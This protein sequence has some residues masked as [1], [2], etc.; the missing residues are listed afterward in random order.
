MHPLVP[1]PFLYRCAVRRQFIW[2]KGR[3]DGSVGLSPQQTATIAHVGGSARGDG[4]VQS[5]GGARGGR[6]VDGREALS[7]LP[8]NR[9][10]PHP[11]REQRRHRG[12]TTENRAGPAR[13]G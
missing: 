10:A 9:S 4:P 1:S 8:A 13:E 12:P 11:A 7:L 2:R 6:A 3:R 5:A